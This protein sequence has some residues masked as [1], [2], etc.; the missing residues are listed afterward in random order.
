VRCTYQKD[1]QE[2]KYL[3]STSTQS[4]RRR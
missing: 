1:E 4:E 2:V 3:W